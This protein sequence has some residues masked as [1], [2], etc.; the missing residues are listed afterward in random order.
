MKNYAD[1][2][3]KGIIALTLIFTAGALHAQDYGM[4][5]TTGETGE[6]VVDVIMGSDDHTIMATLLQESMLDET[7][8]QGPS[9]TV[10]APTDAAFAE[11]GDAVQEL[12][13]NPEQLQQ[14]MLNHL[15][16]G[17]AS[18]EDVQDALD[19]EI[20]QG[21]IPASNG[22]VHSIDRVLLQ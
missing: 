19:L 11:L 5:A 8:A 4:P 1:R 12:R 14:V 20:E 2:M 16:Q 15:F 13:Q 22:V 17:S 9:F 6:T 18:A 7:L 21:D 10:L 3:M